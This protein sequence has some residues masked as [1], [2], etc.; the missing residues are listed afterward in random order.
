MSILK[1]ILV[2]IFCLSGAVLTAVDD[3][4]IESRID[5]KSFYSGT[6]FSY[7]ILVDGSDLVQPQS[8][9][10][11]KEFSIK[12]IDAKALIKGSKKGFSI[13]YLLVPQLFGDLTVPSFSV[14]VNSKLHRTDEITVNVKKPESPSGLKLDVT[15]PSEKVYVGQPFLVTF[16]WYSSLP[17]Y[18]FRGVNIDLPL[19]H[20]SAFKIFEGIDSI[21]PG[22]SR[23]IGLP[24]SN[25]RVIAKRGNAEVDGKQSEFLRFT[26]VVVPVKP[27]VF[28]I[29]PATLLT[30]YLPPPPP[31]PVVKNRRHR[32]YRPQYPSYFNNNFFDD[33]GNKPFQRFFVQSES[34]TIT[35]LP[36]PEE[37]VPVG[38][39]GVVGKCKLEVSAEPLELRVGDPLTLTVKIKEY[40]YPSTL[41][42]PPLSYEK[43]FRSSF[44]IASRQPLGVS[45]NRDRV[46]KRI[47][48]PLRINVTAV[49]P[50]RVP[51]FDLETG[52]YGV[53]VSAPIPIKVKPAETATTFDAE[54]SG[55]SQLVNQIEPSPRGVRHNIYNS[56]IAFS[57]NLI[58]LKYLFAIFAII[59]PLLFLFIYLLSANYRLKKDD[60]VRARAKFAAGRFYKSLDQIKI[61]DSSEKR[62]DIELLN[63]IDN[64]FRRYFSEKFNIQPHAHTVIDLKAILEAKKVD[65][66]SIDD[67][68]QVYNIC[69]MNRYTEKEHG[70]TVGELKSQVLKCVK[71]IERK[72]G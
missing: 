70:K 30:S 29:H 17:L 25:R 35:V 56:E 31:R 51:Y 58:N 57:D 6:P 19:F 60:P 72:V 44:L 52:K 53:E 27:G 63:S 48:R 68:S 2:L 20:N 10:V 71:N 62:P 15:V 7:T 1:K 16:T 24:V 3:I 23:S 8:I 47:I 33:V 59:P 55:D 40:P 21:K 28:T 39:F 9:P 11:S 38:F 32:S 42:L 34:R 36:L 66:E 65:K 43:A 18:A 22:G 54:L 26:R 37:G 49:P 4:H 61:S 67:I 45:E 14:T 41:T 69:S 5:T 64:I 46:F 12:L 50:V 13:R